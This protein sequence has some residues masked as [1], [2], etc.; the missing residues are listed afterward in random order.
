MTPVNA[1]TAFVRGPRVSAGNA[2]GARHAS[3]QRNRAGRS[4][5]MRT[6]GV[7][8][9]SHACE[10]CMMPLHYVRRCQQGAPE[11][12]RSER[13]SGKRSAAGSTGALPGGSL[14][15]RVQRGHA[16]H[17]GIGRWSNNHVRRSARKP[18]RRTRAGATSSRNFREDRRAG[19]TRPGV[20]PNRCIAQLASHS[21]SSKAGSTLRSSRAVPHPST[22]R[23]L[24]RL[25]SEVGRDPVHSTRY[26]RR[27]TTYTTC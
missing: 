17:G 12:S 8:L 14:P 26:G 11:W 2:T 18:R 13:S 19:K 3:D 22:N 1:S 20:R 4:A 23:A 6:P 25:T 27:R 7:E 9:G 21:E 10:A 15:N 16:G 24:R 5:H